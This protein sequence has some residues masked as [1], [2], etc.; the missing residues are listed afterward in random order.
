MWGPPDFGKIEG[1]SEADRLQRQEDADDCEGSAP[2]A[3]HAGV[4]L[5]MLALLGAGT[6]GFGGGS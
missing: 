3:N 5:V 6:S 2:L 1:E 4:L